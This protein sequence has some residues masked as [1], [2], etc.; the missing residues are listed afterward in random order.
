[1]W[2]TEGEPTA[3]S[4][5]NRGWHND[6]ISGW[7]HT[8]PKSNV[9]LMIGSLFITKLVMYSCDQYVHKSN[10]RTVTKG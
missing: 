2:G 8:N 10:K 6:M 5:A 4:A 7:T 1:M 9:L 3:V